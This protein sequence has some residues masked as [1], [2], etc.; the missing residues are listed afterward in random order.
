MERKYLAPSIEILSVSAEDII[1]TSPTIDLPW[2]SVED[3]I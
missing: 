2:V 1:S 3:E